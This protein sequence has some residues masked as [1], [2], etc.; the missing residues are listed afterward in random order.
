MDIDSLARSKYACKAASRVMPSLS[1]YSCKE[2]AQCEPT[3]DV[4]AYTGRMN[5]A[6]C[7]NTQ[8]STA[9]SA[10]AVPTDILAL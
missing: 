8:K 9:N 10:Q 1:A 6:L 5:K 2:V 3:V 4:M 7:I